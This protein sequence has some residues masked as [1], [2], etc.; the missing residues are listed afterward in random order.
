MPKP[1]NSELPDPKVTAEPK[2]EKRERRSHPSE[3]KLKIIA[4]ADACQHGEL[5]ELL[6]REGLYSGQLKQWREEFAS[7]DHEK[8]SKTKPGPTAKLT[9][10]QREIEKLKAKIT[11]LSRE[12][13]ITQGCVD[14]QKKALA[15]LD[16][17]SNGKKP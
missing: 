14:L 8:L 3:Y 16:L 12:L 4:E 2:L 1:L 9:A 7:G 6:R 11:L 17:Q 13:E 15:M 10:E 5:G